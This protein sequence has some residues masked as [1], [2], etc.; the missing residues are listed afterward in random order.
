[1]S[2]VGFSGKNHPQ[3]V[4]ARGADDNVDDRGTDPFFDA[5]HKKHGFTLDVAASPD[6]AK[7]ERF[8]TKEQ[9]GLAQPWARERVWCNPPYSNIRHW[10]EKAW[11]EY[12]RTPLIVMLLPAN[13]TE[14]GWWQELVEPYRDFPSSPLKVQ[15]LPGRMRFVRAGRDHI[16]ANERP[17]FGC[18][19]LRWGMSLPS[20]T[21]PRLEAASQGRFGL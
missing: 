10:V 7:C 9:D 17:P 16:G 13:R 8:F 20:F 14:Q 5:L 1:M 15:F 18:C 2:L 12:P 6:N 3:Q 19:L 11:F 4:G 21:G